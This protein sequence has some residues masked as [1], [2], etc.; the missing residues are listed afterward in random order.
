MNNEINQ[1]FANQKEIVAVAPTSI[2]ST[3]DVLNII[4]SLKQKTLIE[5]EKQPI[6]LTKAN[7]IEAVKDAIYQFDFNEFVSSEPELCGAYGDSFSL[8]INTSFDDHEFVR[9]FIEVLN[10][11]LSPNK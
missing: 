2:Y 6:V 4:E 3:E 8:E 7:V 11:Y 1:L 9:E 5:V 10:D